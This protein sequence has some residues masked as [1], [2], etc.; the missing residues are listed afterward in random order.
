MVITLHSSIHDRSITLFP[1]TF[2]CDLVIHPI[3]I[4]PHGIIDLAK[5]HGRAGII[6]DGCLEVIVEVA[7]VQEDIGVVEP[8]VKVSFD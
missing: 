1:D 3:R 6:L 2:L 4:T 7:V 5:F 8:P